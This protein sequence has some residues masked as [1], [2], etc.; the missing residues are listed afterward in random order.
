[1]SALV[2]INDNIVARLGAIIPD[3]LAI[4]QILINSSPIIIS[5]YA[6]FGL[7]SVVIIAEVLFSQYIL[8]CSDLNLSTRSCNLSLTCSTGN[9]SPITPVDAKIKSLILTVSF[10]PFLDFD[11]FIVK[12]LDKFFASRSILSFPCL[13]VNVFAFLY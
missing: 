4:P 11:S 1:M 7:V 12:I 10:V 9:S 8:L 13:P 6:T 3:P 5:S 2:N